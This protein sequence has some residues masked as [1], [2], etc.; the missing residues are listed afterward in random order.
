MRIANISSNISGENKSHCLKIAIM[1][2]EITAVMS[3]LMLEIQNF[4]FSFKKLFY[5]KYSKYRNPNKK[6]HEIQNVSSEISINVMTNQ[7]TMF[8]P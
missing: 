8:H 1:F 7:F 3:I 6:L 5:K 2:I 4:L